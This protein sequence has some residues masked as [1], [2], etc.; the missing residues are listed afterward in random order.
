[1]NFRDYREDK[2]TEIGT[3]MWRMNHS[4][5]EGLKITF[6][7]A[8][9]MRGAGHEQ[10]LSPEFDHWDGYRV[11]LP[12]CKIE[13]ASW[14]GEQ[15]PKQQDIVLG[16]G[17]VENLPCPFCGE[18]P[19]WSYSGRFIGA[20]PIQSESWR[21]VCCQWAGTVRFE[22]PLDLASDRNARLEKNS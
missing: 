16:V 18:V 19:K 22:N 11:N 6:L 5:I 9:R 21:L 2:P 3:Y 14:D 13:W 7:A 10:V 15:N 12:Q 17:G 1:M 4:Y 8:F 20:C